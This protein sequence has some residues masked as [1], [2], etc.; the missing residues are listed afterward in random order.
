MAVF[1]Q[2]GSG[3]AAHCSDPA[4]CPSAQFQFLPSSELTYSQERTE[5]EKQAVSE[6]RGLS[7]AGNVIC[8]SER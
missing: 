3:E 4:L 8:L 6:P 1:T 7:E 2:E 5:D